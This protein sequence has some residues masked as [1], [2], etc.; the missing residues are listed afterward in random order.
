MQEYFLQSVIFYCL[1]CWFSDILKT[2][3]L[4]LEVFLLDDCKNIEPLHRNE[5]HL[6]FYAKKD[7]LI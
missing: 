6:F 7:C 5:M 3:T 4:K 1:V 2:L